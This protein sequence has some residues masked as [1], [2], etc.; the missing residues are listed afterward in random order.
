ML[1]YVSEIQCQ[2]F[3]FLKNIK[4]NCYKAKIDDCFMARSFFLF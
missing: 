3:L 4:K 2:A 1:K